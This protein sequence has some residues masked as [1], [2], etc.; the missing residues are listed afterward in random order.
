MLCVA[1]LGSHPDSMCRWMNTLFKYGVKFNMMAQPLATRPFSPCGIKLTLHSAVGLRQSALIA[2]SVLEFTFL[3]SR[4][5][6]HVPASRDSGDDRQCRSATKPTCI[7]TLRCRPTASS[8]NCSREISNR[9][10]GLQ[11]IDRCNGSTTGL[12]Y[13]RCWQTGSTVRTA[14]VR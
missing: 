3:P 7:I 1:T 9:S 8:V 12:C 5:C 6:L 10:S 13:V 14:L 4:S 11:K 2:L